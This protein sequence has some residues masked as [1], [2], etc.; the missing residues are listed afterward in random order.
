MRNPGIT[1]KTDNEEKWFNRGHLKSDLK[2]RSVKGGISTVSGQ[3]IMLF[4]TV[5]STAV[6]ARL[7]APED[8]GLVV[9]VTAFTGFITTFKDMGLSAAIIQRDNIT[10]TEVSVLFW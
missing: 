3:V 9:M 2:T 10:Q 5:V 4:F 1:G 6:M 7:L 8:F